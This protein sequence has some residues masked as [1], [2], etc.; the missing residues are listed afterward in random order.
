LAEG[1][2]KVPVF[3]PPQSKK[4]PYATSSPALKLL[5]VASVACPGLTH[6]T[7]KTQG[8]LEKRRR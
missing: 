3:T 1:L 4:L 8:A 7:P 2:E 5:G 6:V